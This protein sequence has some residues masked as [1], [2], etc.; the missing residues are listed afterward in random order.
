MRA[1]GEQVPMAEFARPDSP[2]VE[3]FLPSP[4]HGDRRDHARPNCLILHYTGMQSALGAIELLRDPRAEVSCHYVVAEDGAIFQLV[5]ESRRAWHAGVSVWKGERD[6]N[7]ASIGVE[8]CNAGHDGGLPPFPKRQIEAT[9]ALC[10]DVSARHAI[11]PERVLA[12]SDIAPARK[13]DPGERFPWGILARAGV[14][15]WVEPAPI[16]DGPLFE[17]GREGPHVRALQALL[18]LYG[19]GLEMSGVHDHATET[20]VTAFQ[21]HFRPELV[22]GAADTSTFETLRALIGALGPT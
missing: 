22:D 7:S 15:H 5:A 6:I 14:G 2:L 8:I 16:S 18:S 19:Y 21:R 11:R 13:R 20:V 4:N 9:I 17:R 1:S 12:H 10:L 3:R